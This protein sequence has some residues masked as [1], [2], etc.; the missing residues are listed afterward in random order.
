VG[1]RQYANARRSGAS[2]K[3]AREKRGSRASQA[4]IALT[5]PR[6]F[7]KRPKT[8]VLQSRKKACTGCHVANAFLTTLQQIWLVFR[9]KLSKTFLFAK[10]LWVSMSNQ[11]GSFSFHVTWNKILGAIMNLFFYS[12]YEGEQ[13]P[14]KIIEK[15]NKRQTF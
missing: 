9:L 8:T 2:V 7:Q 15:T 11:R 10:E 5:A 14:L 6:P 1:D 12:S 3:T 4:R 13:K